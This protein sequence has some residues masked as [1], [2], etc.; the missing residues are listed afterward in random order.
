MDSILKKHNVCYNIITLSHIASR[1]HTNTYMHHIRATYIHAIHTHTRNT[2]T[3]T[4]IPDAIND[5]ITAVMPLES[6]LRPIA[7]FSK[8]GNSARVMEPRFLSMWNFRIRSF[9]R[10]SCLE[11]VA[12]TGCRV[13]KGGK[14]QNS[15]GVKS[16]LA[17]Y[18][19]ALCMEA[20]PHCTALHCTAL[21]CTALH[22][23]ALHCTG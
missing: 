20:L 4:H 17:I 5:S 6:I 11:R 10:A 18:V 23:T 3:R 16:K 9:H 7:L 14:L 2:H 13:K 1:L 15:G 12:S 22:C 21:H 19:Q 8:Y